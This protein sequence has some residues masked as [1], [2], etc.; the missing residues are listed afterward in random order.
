M[1][2]GDRSVNVVVNPGGLVIYY[3]KNHI[4]WGS[5]QIV[6]LDEARDKILLCHNAVHE[7]RNPI[8]ERKAM[9]Q[10]NKTE[11]SIISIRLCNRWQ[12]IATTIWKTVLPKTIRWLR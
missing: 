9:R 12:D 8:E 4:Y 2:Y 3:I 5:V 11:Q 1:D 6:S 10:N 7:G